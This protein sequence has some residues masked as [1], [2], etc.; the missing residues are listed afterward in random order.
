MEQFISKEQLLF[1]FSIVFKHGLV[2]KDTMYSDHMITRSLD[3]IYLKRNDTYLTG[4]RS[5]F[6][7]M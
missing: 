1:P 4:S 7:N 6:L 2:R 3:K 5:Q